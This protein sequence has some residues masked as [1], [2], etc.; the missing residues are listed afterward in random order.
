MARTIMILVVLAACAFMAGWFTID[1][2]G[3]DTT[4]RFNRDEI[5]EDTS[6]ALAR[7]REFLNEQ[8]GLQESIGE[9]RENVGEYVEQSGFA[10]TQQA[11][12]PSAPWEQPAFDPN[13]GQ[14]Y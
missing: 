5:R 3:D 2:E 13:G 8:D 9:V 1:R 7:G 10:P 6:A 11:N 12:L 4:I 14:Q